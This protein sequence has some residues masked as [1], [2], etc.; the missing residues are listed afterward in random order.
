MT[1]MT[2]MTNNYTNSTSTQAAAPAFEQMR[3]SK[4]EAVIK[5]I[6]LILLV[7]AARIFI[8]ALMR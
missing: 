6:G 2:N 7:I 1:N 8:H 4:S 3:E 5:R